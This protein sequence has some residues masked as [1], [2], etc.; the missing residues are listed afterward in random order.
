MTT[1]ST[2]LTVSRTL[3]CDARLV[4]DHNLSHEHDGG[5]QFRFKVQY[6][7]SYGCCRRQGFQTIRPR[8]TGSRSP[9]MP[10]GRTIDEAYGN[11]LLP[12]R[13]RP[14][15][16]PAGEPVYR[17]SSQI[18]NLAYKWDPVGNLSLAVQL[19][20]EYASPAHPPGPCGQI[21]SSEK[22]MITELVLL[23]YD[24]QKS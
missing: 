19:M 13:P 4:G 6:D 24:R 7:Y 14:G 16:G 22:R 5:C 12:I 23:L 2:S 10:P 1:G 20:P 11:N 9:P 15:Y 21:S 3:Q 18:Q 8:C 17:A